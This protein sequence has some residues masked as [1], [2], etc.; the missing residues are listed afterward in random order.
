M[1]NQHQLEPTKKFPF[2]KSFVA[3]IDI[4]GFSERFLKDPELCLDLLSEFAKHNGEHSDIND[5]QQRQIRPNSLCFSDNIGISIP[6]ELNLESELMPNEFYSPLITILHSIS[7]FAYYALSKGM[8]I[9]GA[10]AYGD[11]HQSQTVIALTTFIY[12]HQT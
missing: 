11:M 2:K 4:L 3:F 6:A 10:I 9:R 1:P 12:S 5:S 8:L 7:F